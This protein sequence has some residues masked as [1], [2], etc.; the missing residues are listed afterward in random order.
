MK[1]LD[2]WLRQA[3]FYLTLEN[4]MQ[5]FIRW[6]GFLGSLLSGVVLIAQG[7]IEVGVGVITAGLSSA[8][9][10]PESK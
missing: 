6:G 9:I 10:I 1:Y 7:Q 4:R 2:T 3:A 5:K 8:S